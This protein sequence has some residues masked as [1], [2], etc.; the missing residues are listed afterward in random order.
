MTVGV[1]GASARA[2]VHS[3]AR[4]GLTAWA[5][6]QFNDR[7]LKRVA[8]CALCPPDEYPAALPGLA[9]RFPPGPFLYTGGLENHPHIVAELTRTRELWGNPPEVLAR[10]RDPHS[11][12]ACGF[13][14]NMPRL[15]PAGEPCPRAGRWLRKPLRSAGGLGI[16]FA[17]PAEPASPRHYFQE[18][19]AGVPMSAIYTDD[20]LLGVTEQL[21]GEPWLHTP[22]F[23]YCGNVGPIVAPVPALHAPALRGVWGIDFILSNGVPFPVEVNPRYTAGAEVL[24]HARG[25]EEP[26]PPAPAEPT[27]PAPLPKGK[28]EQDVSLRSTAAE[29]SAS[30]R[31]SSSPFPLGRGAGGVGSCVGKAIYYAAHAFHFPASGPW[32]ADLAGPF[33]P[34]RLPGFADIPD[35]GSAIQPGGPVL[36]FFAHGRTPAETR[37]RLQSRAAELDHL[38]AEHLT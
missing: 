5:V 7:D 25:W 11:L 27:P 9:A 14:G 4:A 37:K 15:V 23:A 38:F 8:P 31:A 35:A 10:V 6:D 20:N 22:P 17:H 1:V 16:R 28:G 19:I 32:D 21:I 13:A 30:E 29:A 24:E 36:T 26:T 3:L 33:D 12:A 18:F 2:A 34:W